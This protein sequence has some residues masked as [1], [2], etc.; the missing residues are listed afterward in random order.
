[1]YIKD[2]KTTEMRYNVLVNMKKLFIVLRAAVL[3]LII[4][5]VFV[6]NFTAIRGVFALLPAGFIVLLLCVAILYYLL[7]GIAYCFAFENSNQISLKQGIVLSMLGMFANVTSAGVGAVPLQTYYLHRQGIA[8]GNAAGTFLYSYVIHKLS[9][10][11]LALICICISFLIGHPDLRPFYPYIIFG[12]TVDIIV[13]VLMCA[14]ALNKKINELAH[15]LCAKLPDRFAKQ[16]EAL[17]HNLDL[18]REEVSDLLKNTKTGIKVLIADLCK[19]MAMCIVV[20]LIC[21][22]MEYSVTFGE[23]LI[24]MA[25]IFAISGSLPN[26]SGFG[27]IELGFALFFGP[28]IGEENVAGLVLVYRLAN[29]FFPFF[30][31]L[32]IVSSVRRKE[33]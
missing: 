4:Y 11:L 3:L 1:M 30:I 16:R 29:Y 27:P 25:L 8:A 33:E 9:T 12:F 13:C 20:A 22:K 5:F 17:I 26:V 19:F 24:Y 21:Y 32:F 15:K 2:G 31:S 6:R 23:A 28:Q 10:V 18:L 7:E 14:A